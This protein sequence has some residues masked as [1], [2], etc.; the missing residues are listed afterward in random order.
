MSRDP[1][2]FEQDDQLKFEHDASEPV[3]GGRLGENLLLF[4]GIGLVL[5]ATG[6]A[7][8]NFLS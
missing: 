4:A 2:P 8:T 7:L 3:P 1:D 6:M 5:L